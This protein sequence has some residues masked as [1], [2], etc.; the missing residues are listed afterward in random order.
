MLMLTGVVT[1]VYGKGP[2]HM[3]LFTSPR[4]PGSHYK[5]QVDAGTAARVRALINAENTTAQIAEQMAAQ[6]TDQL[7]NVDDEDNRP[8]DPFGRN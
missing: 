8:H 6:L 1:E 5:V 7:F 3:L 2:C 4:V